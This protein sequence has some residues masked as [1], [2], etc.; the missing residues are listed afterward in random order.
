MQA[1]TEIHLV[2]HGQTDWNAT[3]RVQGQAESRLTETGWAQARAFG[4]RL[5]LSDFDAVY[6]SSALRTRQTLEGLLRGRRC[7]PVY[8][9]ALREIHLGPWQGHL[10]QYVAEIWPAEF[11]DFKHRPGQFSLDGAETFLQLQQRGLAAI[12]AIAA[13]HRGAKVLAVSH[14]ALIKAVYC[15]IADRPLDHVWQDPLADNCA[16]FTVSVDAD[17]G[18]QFIA[19]TPGGDALM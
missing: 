1:Q 2:R 9:D 6:C 11:E 18:R 3:E 4:A 15:A 5:E 13:A 17:G 12:D 7:T 8:R 19:F 14:G 10:R 16:Q